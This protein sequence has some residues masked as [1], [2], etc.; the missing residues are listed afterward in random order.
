MGDG[1]Q[2]SGRLIMPDDLARCGLCGELMPPGEEMFRF[3][4]YSGPCPKPALQPPCPECPPGRKPHA[5]RVGEIDRLLKV[6][7]TGAVC[8]DDTPVHRAWYLHEIGKYPKLKVVFQGR[9][10]QGIY[11]IKVEKLP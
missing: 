4:G 1:C 9:L 3:H 11:V 6:G 10:G 8:I 2:A 7:H 5:E